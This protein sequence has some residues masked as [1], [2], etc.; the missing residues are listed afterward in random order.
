MVLSRVLLLTF[1]EIFTF[2]VPQ[3]FLVHREKSPSDRE[4]DTTMARQGSSAEVKLWKIF[5]YSVFSHAK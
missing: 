4:S 2:K 1:K 5:S 3:G